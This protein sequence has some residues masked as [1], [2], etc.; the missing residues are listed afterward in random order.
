VWN[1]AVMLA[2]MF[3]GVIGLQWWL[4]TLITFVL[5][6]PLSWMMYYKRW[7]GGGF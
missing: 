3:A 6:A 2:A 1:T 7:A 4:F 5:G